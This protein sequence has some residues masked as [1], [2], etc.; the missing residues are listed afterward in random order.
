MEAA[1]LVKQARRKAGLSQRSLALRAGLPQST[2]GRIE[3]GTTDPRTG[4]LNKILEAC[5]FEL[6]VERR[7]GDGVDRTQIR[8]FL[9]L[10][11]K[12]RLE[13]ATSAARNLA[14]LK[15]GKWVG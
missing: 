6:E 9:A 3:A 2:I 10:S 12:Q 5:G 7:L 14:R 13:A 8:E 15:K 4:T 1:R 11:P